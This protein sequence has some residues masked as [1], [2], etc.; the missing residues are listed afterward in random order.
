MFHHNYNF[1]TF[2]ELG[3]S[4][5]I[6]GVALTINRTHIIYSLTQCKCG[7]RNE[8]ST[9]VFLNS[10]QSHHLLQI[11]SLRFFPQLLGTRNPNYICKNILGQTQ[12]YCTC[13]PQIQI[14]PIFINNTRIFVAYTFNRTWPFSRS[15][16]YTRLYQYILNLHLPQAKVVPSNFSTSKIFYD[17]GYCRVTLCDSNSQVCHIAG[18]FFFS[19]FFF[20]H[21]VTFFLGGWWAPKKIKLSHKY[22]QMRVKCLSKL[23][24]NPWRCVIAS[25][26]CVHI[27]P[28]CSR[29][30]VCSAT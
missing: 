19:F 25:V 5:N 13:S 9:I 8:N 11:Q 16:V 15:L 7:D 10:R 27:T 3:V 18:Y 12:T 20:I 2:E 29:H 22:T 14:L 21:F 1:I 26:M 23:R 6:Q 30:A 24:E 17:F 28:K 4:Y